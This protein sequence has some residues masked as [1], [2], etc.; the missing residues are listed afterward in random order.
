MAELAVVVDKKQ[1]R[2]AG[3]TE[4][5]LAAIA[6]ASRLVGATLQMLAEYVQ[7][8]VE[9]QYLDRIAEEYIRAHGGEPAF[10]GYGG[11]SQ[12]LSFPSTLCVSIDN[13]V[14]HGIPS[15]RRLE[16]GQIVSIDCGVRYDG[17]Y[18]DGAWSFAVGRVSDEKQ[19][20]LAVTC[21]ALYRGIEQARAGNTT[22]DIARAIQQHVESHRFSCVRE[23]VGH[24]VGTSLHEE[25]AV[26][27]FV[28]GLL[29]RTRYRQAVL[30][31]GMTIAI[32][33]MVTA[34]SFTVY[35]ARD[36]WTVCT[37]DGKPSAHFEHTVLVK[38]DGAEILTVHSLPRPQYAQ[39]R[40]DQS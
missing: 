27:N 1:Q 22:Y 30:T 6:E 23:L 29:H 38:A 37:T 34:G 19:R 20:L 5:E 32:E 11:G 33:P 7:P 17:C 21:E 10:K 9:T 4:A 40:A 12:T 26:P 28:P 8:G 25:P 24:G 35:T 2:P 14:V 3:H 15:R 39:A 16:E 36:G 31:E 18:G 13:E